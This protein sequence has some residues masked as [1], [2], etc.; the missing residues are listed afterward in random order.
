VALA[1]ILLSKAPTPCKTSASTVRRIETDPGRVICRAALGQAT[2]TDHHQQASSAVHSRPCAVL[3]AACQLPPA[4]TATALSLSRL[5]QSLP[6]SH[7]LALSPITCFSIPCLF[8]LHPP[9]CTLRQRQVC[10]GAR[11]P[12]RPVSKLG[13]ASPVTST[14]SHLSP[15][16]APSSLF[17][18]LQQ[19][20]RAALHRGVKDSRE[21]LLPARCPVTE[22]RAAERLTEFQGFSPIACHS[23]HNTRYCYCSTQRHPS[24]LD[25]P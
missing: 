8:L 1:V 18:R 25:S 7:L 15:L 24:A 12:E 23:D 19:Q 17:P 16:R 6:T 14:S 2:G 11:V 5:P 9:A 10:C 13:S 20:Y 22:P 21:G 4:S 3:T